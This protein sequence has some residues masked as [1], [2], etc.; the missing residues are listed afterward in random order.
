MRIL[1]Q[2]YKN[3]FD[4]KKVQNKNISVSKNLT[5]YIELFLNSIIIKSYRFRK[6]EIVTEYVGEMIRN[7]V[8][9]HREIRYNKTGFGDCY[10]FK[11][12][13]D[14]VIDATFRGSSARYLNHSCNVR[15]TK[16][17]SIF[18]ILIIYYQ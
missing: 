5:I 15:E 11:A 2:Y 8:T 1:L 18:T 14:L 9:D 16:L 17:N 13:R 6:Y 3:I 10:M 12:T 4:L 7:S